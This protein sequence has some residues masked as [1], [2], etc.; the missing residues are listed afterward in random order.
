[1]TGAELAHVRTT[2]GLTVPQMA[3]LLGA[4]KRTYYRW[5]GAKRISLTAERLIVT[6]LKTP[7]LLWADIA[8]IRGE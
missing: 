1:M 2:L 8:R 7:H 4:N 6:L 5:E 3:A